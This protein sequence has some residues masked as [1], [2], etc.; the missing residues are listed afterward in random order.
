MLKNKSMISFNI[1]TIEE[2]SHCVELRVDELGHM[3][4]TVLEDK[5]PCPVAIY[6]L[7]PNIHEFTD[8]IRRIENIYAECEYLQ[9]KHGIDPNE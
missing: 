5:E 2:E 7:K 1:Y 3:W 6:R 9:P 8:M 4:L